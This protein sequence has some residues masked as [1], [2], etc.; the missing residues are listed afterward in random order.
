MSMTEVL[1]G[2]GLTST[3]TASISGTDT[4]LAIQSSDAANWPAA[5]VYRAVLWQDSTVG[6][7]ELVRVVGGQGTSTLTIQRAAE[8]YRGTQTARAW[9]SGTGIAAVIT[10]DGLTQ[11]LAPGSLYGA[12]G[13]RTIVSGWTDAN[14]L[15]ASLA[16]PVLGVTHSFFHA[17][18]SPPGGTFVDT[19]ETNLGMS[20]MCDLPTPLVELRWYRQP[21]DTGPTTHQFALYRE[22]DQ[23]SIW[24]GS[25]SSEVSGWNSM[26]VSGITLNGGAG[27]RYVI[28]SVPGTTRHTGSVS[29]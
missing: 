1:P 17:T 10:K 11:V 26:P 25:T 3:L 16:V 8:S 27:Y 18:P 20:F 22:S 29:G 5:G 15:L 9:P 28:H 6:P 14:S 13:T 19:A 12:G 7:W 23:S 24:T 4:S 2:N 21:T